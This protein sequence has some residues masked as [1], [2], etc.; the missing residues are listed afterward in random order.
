M[1]IV[2]TKSPYWKKQ[3]PILLVGLA[4]LGLLA[5]MGYL[6]HVAEEHP[7]KKMTPVERKTREHIHA[8][9]LRSNGDFSQIN[10]EDKKWLIKLAGR[11]DFAE[12]AY[13][14][15]KA[16]PYPSWW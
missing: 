11:Q 15:V 9:V 5:L 16:N 6:N 10:P 2:L 3:A 7:I 4:I 13:N 8:I 14:D 12:E 1:T